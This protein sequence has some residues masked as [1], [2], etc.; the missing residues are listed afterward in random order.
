MADVRMTKLGT[1]RIADWRFPRVLAA[2]MNLDAI[3]K[4]LNCHID[5]ILGRDVLC[6]RG[7][8]L[9]LS[10]LQMYFSCRKPR[11]LGASQTH[12]FE[13]DITFNAKKLIELELRLDAQPPIPGVLDLGA[14]T[15]LTNSAGLVCLGGRKLPADGQSLAST[16]MGADARPLDVQRARVKQF[17]IGT[18]L[19]PP[20]DICVADLPV[21]DVLGYQNK[22]VVL[23]GLD[24][25]QDKLLTIHPKAH[26]LTISTAS[27]TRQI[28][29]MGM[30]SS[31][32]T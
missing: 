25:F 9:N 29:P 8:S 17:A 7:F 13:S 21:F 23:L 16:G 26:R 2:I 20:M 12:H 32:A 6:Q 10:A 22:P 28:N 15:T 4:R 18:F 19:F 3:I 24:L 5:G 1:L 14:T 11:I 30:E 31:S 27:L